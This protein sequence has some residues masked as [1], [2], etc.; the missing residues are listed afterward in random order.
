M[1]VVDEC[2]G[3]DKQAKL[4][5]TITNF[6]INQS[7]PLI[8]FF[9]S[10]AENQIYSEFRSPVL[11]DILLQLPLDTDY[12]ADE[13][14]LLFLNHSF[15]KIKS[16]HSYA[17]DL[18][19]QN[20]PAEGDVKEIMRKGSGQFIYASVAINFISLANQ[21]PAQQLK[22]VLGLQPPRILKPF[23][24]L[25][26]LYQHI[27][28]Q[29]VDIQATSL[30]LACKMFYRG[31]TLLA[32]SQIILLECAHM[33]TDDIKAAL[34]ALIPILTYDSERGDINFLHASLPD[35]LGDK[36]R[37]QAYHIDRAM[38]STKLSILVFHYLMDKARNKVP[39]SNIE[40]NVHPD[41]EHAMC[42]QIHIRCVY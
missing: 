40:E 13:D 36:D 1:T 35:F 2:N 32:P 37:S 24:Q 7:F 15:A 20:W 33:T 14:I 38:W 4:I 39:T 8:A 34:S 25:D 17:S 10:R 23:A 21:H 11:S 42:C 6:V 31:N 22:I 19:A 18:C 27:F 26:A 30:V 28:S 9:G 16:T 29:V 41:C 5:Q 3:H 12:R